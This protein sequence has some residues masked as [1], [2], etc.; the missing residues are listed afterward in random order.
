MNIGD[1]PDWENQDDKVQSDGEGLIAQ[2]EGI[3]VYARG[4]CDVHVP[5]S[6]DWGAAEHTDEKLHLESVSNKWSMLILLTAAT[7]QPTLSAAAMISGI[8]LLPTA[9][10]RQYRARSES[11][12]KVSAT[13]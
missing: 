11:L 9:K 12:L 2:E 10:R 6:F 5:E 7:I 4:S 8:L 13:G 1:V 3:E